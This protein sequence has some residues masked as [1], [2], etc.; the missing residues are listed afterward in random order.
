MTFEEWWWN[1]A[2]R[3]YRNFSNDV[4]SEAAWIESKKQTEQRVVDDVDVIFR[5]LANDKQIQL[6]Q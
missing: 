2:R 6:G 1:H 5:H 4:A 3:E